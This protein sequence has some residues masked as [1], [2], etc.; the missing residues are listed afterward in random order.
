MVLSVV[1]GAVAVG[2]FAYAGI[3]YASARDEQGKVT[4]AKTI[5]RNVTIGLVLYVMTIAIIGW[6]LP[7]TVVEAPED[8]TGTPAS[9]GSVTTP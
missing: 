7:G 9:S 3:I 5:M 1:I 4:E 2:A 6:L 8:T